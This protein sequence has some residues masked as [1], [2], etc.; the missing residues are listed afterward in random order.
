MAVMN[1]ELKDVLSGEMTPKFLATLD[2][3]GR[4]NC[5]PVITIMP[6]DDDHLIFGEFLMN[7]SRKNL[8]VYDK[9][10]VSVFDDQYRAWSLKGTF[11]GFETKGEWVDYMNRAPMFRYNAYT[12]VRAAGMIRVDDISPKFQVSKGRLVWD[13]L[14]VKSAALG[15]QSN[16]TEHRCMPRQVEE[17]FGRTAAVRA[18]AFRDTDGYPRATS[19]ITCIA[20]GPNRVV[21]ADP[22]T[23]Q[24]ATEMAQAK[25]LAIP[26]ITMDPIAYQ[27]KGRLSR[28]VGGVHVVELTACY[29]ASPPLSGDRL[30]TVPAAIEPV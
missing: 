9:V 2:A 21:F 23:A 13:L 28:T 19:L 4:P 24:Y 25:D 12:G 6:Y 15:L 8:S 17:K 27:V 11:V 10:G 18:V 5:V 30:D 7:K 20:A 22:M 26:I 1:A 3:D 14:R 29:S 16:A